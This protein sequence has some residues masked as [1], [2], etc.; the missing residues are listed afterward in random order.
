MLNNKILKSFWKKYVLVVKCYLNSF[1]LLFSAKFGL[2][3][4]IYV[5]KAFTHILPL[6][7]SKQIFSKVKTFFRN[8]RLNIS[9][10]LLQ[11]LTFKLGSQRFQG[12]IHQ[13]FMLNLQLQSLYCQYFDF[14]PIF[15]LQILHHFHVHL[16]TTHNTSS[17]KS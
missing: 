14:P 6:F 12:L 15:V 9:V 8:S 3:V 10:H 1:F 5:L 2:F 13:L 17:L 11:S 7:Q 16:P 4:K